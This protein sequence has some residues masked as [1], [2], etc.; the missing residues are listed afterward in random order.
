[1]TIEDDIAADGPLE[2]EFIPGIAGRLPRMTVAAG[3]IF[4]DP[5]DR[6]LFV[7]PGYKPYLDIPGGLIEP[8]E[9]PSEACRREVQEE[10]GWDIAPG[11]LLVVDWTPGRG[12]WFDQVQFVFDGGVQQSTRELRLQADELTAAEWLPLD[13]AV[14]RLRPSAARRIA[15]AVEA[16]RGGVTIHAEFGRRVQ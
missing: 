7:V 14:G 6:I 4:T 8:G 1:M 15:L 10:L 9:P 16:R 5:E 2:A 12:P 11:Q 13:Q 3:A